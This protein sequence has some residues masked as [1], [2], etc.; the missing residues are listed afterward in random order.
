MKINPKEYLDLADASYEVWYPGLKFNNAG[1]TFT[2]I[3][4]VDKSS[5][6]YG[7]AFEA[8]DGQRIIAHRGTEFTSVMDV[9]R[10][11]TQLAYTNATHVPVLPQQFIDAK[12]FSDKFPGNDVTHTGHSLGGAIGQFC[13]ASNKQNSTSFDAPP[14]ANIIFSQVSGADLKASEHQ[15]FIVNGSLVSAG[16]TDNRFGNVSV[17]YTK[18]PDELGGADFAFEHKIENIKPCFDE[19]GNLVSDKPGYWDK[20]LKE[21]YDKNPTTSF[22]AGGYNFSVSL[23][24]R[25]K[26][27]LEYKNAY[28]KEHNIAP[29]RSNSSI[30]VSGT[31]FEILVKTEI[32]KNALKR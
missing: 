7:V 15:S 27:L 22:G 16:S 25:Y 30:I 31:V 13:A 18:P 28:L 10:T 21:K 17:L 6:Y 3:D 14:I 20:I 11:N 32:L 19:K 8:P 23:Q 29:S 9:L 4:V 1:K 26:N 2:V 24:S 12:E 5:G